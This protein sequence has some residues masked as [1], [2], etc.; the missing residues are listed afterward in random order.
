MGLAF[1][2]KIFVPC[3]GASSAISADAVP[4]ALAL[5][6]FGDRPGVRKSGI[7]RRDGKQQVEV[8]E[9]ESDDENSRVVS[10]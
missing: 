5:Q 3:Q 9:I 7:G 2:Q 10:E 8:L 4:T 6:H 1:G